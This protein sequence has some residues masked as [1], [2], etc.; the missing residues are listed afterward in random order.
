MNRES[1]DWGI[2]GRSR[3]ERS[4]P[5]GYFGEGFGLGGIRG[6]SPAPGPGD[7]RSRG[8]SASPEWRRPR[9]VRGSMDKTVR[10]GRVRPW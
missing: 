4:P 6:C 7:G 3:R 8:A 2:T 5:G 10:V 1:P 9:Y